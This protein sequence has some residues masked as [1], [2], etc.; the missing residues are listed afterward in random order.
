MRYSEDAEMSQVSVKISLL[1]IKSLPMFIE[2]SMDV[3]DLKETLIHSGI[4]VMEKLLV[5]V[6][7][8]LEQVIYLTLHPFRRVINK[9]KREEH[10]LFLFTDDLKYSVY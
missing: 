3:V 5:Q 10:P 8:T 1:I 6:N 9:I 4:K 2:L 7:V